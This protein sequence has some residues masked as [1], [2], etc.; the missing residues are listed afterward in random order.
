[1]NDTDVQL[2]ITDCKPKLHK[3]YK[4]VLQI[5]LVNNN[6]VLGSTKMLIQEHVALGKIRFCRTISTEAPQGCVVSPLLFSLYMK[7]TPKDPPFKLLKFADDT[8]L[9]GLINDSD[10]SACRQ[11]V[12]ELAVW[13]S[14]NNLELNTLKI[15]EMIVD[16]RRKKLIVI[17][18]STLCTMVTGIITSINQDKHLFGV[19]GIDGG[20]CNWTHVLYV[21]SFMPM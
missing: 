10:K 12:K 21:A 11:E 3:N 9:I 19:L 13:C 8:T 4:L 17:L 14:L 20:G 7:C 5:W 16:F 2:T 1:M 18:N 15:V 6:V